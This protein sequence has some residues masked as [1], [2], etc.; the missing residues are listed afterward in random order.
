MVSEVD[1]KKGNYYAA[2]GDFGS[3]GAFSIHYF[4]ALP[5]SFLTV[6]GGEIGYGRAVFAMSPKL[7]ASESG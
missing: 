3:A 4:D 7:P 1:Y 5:R 6:E 2:V